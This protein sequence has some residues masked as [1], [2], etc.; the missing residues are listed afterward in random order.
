[1]MKERIELVHSHENLQVSLENIRKSEVITQNI[2]II[3]SLVNNFN[4]K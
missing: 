4:N 1:M 2:E 3:P